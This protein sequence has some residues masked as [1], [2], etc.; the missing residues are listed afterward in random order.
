MN[1]FKK[2]YEQY[3]E[4][5]SV[6][7]LVLHTA[8]A[9]T[10]TSGLSYIFGLIRDRAFSTQFGLSAELDVYYAAFAIPDLFLGLL[11]TGALSS[12]FIPI[13]SNFEE[14]NKEESIHYTNQ[15]LSYG[16]LLLAIFGG[17]FALILPYVAHHLV[18]FEGAQLE[19][20][21]FVTRWMLLSP[22]LFTISNTF[23]NVLISI[24][25]FLWYGMA[26]IMYNV[27]L[28]F[29]VYVLSPTM[30]LTGLVIGTLLGAA[31]HLA[32]RLPSTLKYGYRFRPDFKFDHKMKETASLMLPK[33][34]QIGM[35]QV[36]LWWFINLASD[37]PEGSVSAYQF[38]RNFQSAP[39]SLLG[40]AI[41]LSAFA[42]LSHLAARKEFGKFARV[43]R[44]KGFLIFFYT[45]LSAIA[46]AVLSKFIITIFLGGGKF[47]PEAI[48]LTA[49]MLAVY[50]IS[51]PFE[52]LMHLL[53]RGHFAL[54]NTL[55]P[56]V[57]HIL[58]ITMT[59]VFSEMLLDEFAILAI[60]ISFAIGPAIQVALLTISLA[61]LLKKKN[62]ELVKDDY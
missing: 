47:G 17:I 43:V 44:R 29:G 14:K 51:I 62:V 21:I 25:D 41:S 49:T 24:K 32:I 38:S 11:V 2:I 45:V 52:S 26:P 12:A 3:K 35:W 33:M 30:G 1:P 48:S 8:F 53:A 5:G 15:V 31:L 37:L 50:A 60:P 16:L 39:V 19:Q 20:Y 27:G 34:L 55:R 23:G 46:L 7:N 22:I 61:Q 40:I 56:S 18:E 13:F 6:K 54:K 59:M 9:L 57:I 28:L 36:L 58:T 42:Q 4:A 10:F